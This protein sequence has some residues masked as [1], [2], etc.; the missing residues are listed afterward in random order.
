MDQTFFHLVFVFVFVTFSVIRIV[1][2]KRTA[3]ARRGAQFKEGK[4]LNLFRLAVGL[5][6]MALVLAYM[7]GPSYWGGRC[8]PAAWAQWT[9]VAL[10]LASLP[11]IVWVRRRWAAISPPRCAVREGTPW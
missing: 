4:L 8:S 2:Q 10:G 5:P 1:Y 7:V 9:G 11:L 6:F 3:S